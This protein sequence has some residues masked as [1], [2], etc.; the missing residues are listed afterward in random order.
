MRRREFLTLL[1][2]TAATWPLAA[3]AQQPESTRKIAILM[4]R[5]ANDAEGE[6]RLA[7]F[8]QTLQQLGWS[9]GRN[10]RFDIRYGEDNIEIERKFASELLALAPDI[11]LASG[12]VSMTALQPLSHTLPI[13]FAVVTDP[14]GAGFVSSLA[15]PG[16][17]A[18]GFMLYE[19]GFGGKWLE[20]LKQIAPSVSRAAIL[21]D[22]TNPSGLAYMAVIRAAAQSLGMDVSPISMSDADEI[23]RGVSAFAR[24]A[25]GAL[26]VTPNSS[27]SVNRALIIRLAARYK[28]PAIYPFDYFATAGGLISYG[29]DWVDQFR[30]AA[31]YVDRILKGEKPADLPVQAPTKYRLVI[32]LKTVKALGLT[33][34]SGMLAGADE[35]IE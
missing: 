12:T 25:N 18:T 24:S 19:Y 22:P 11:I 14:V 15:Q 17:N 31:G 30:L 34:P 9:E 6:A 23:D 16:G 27:A 1:G 2:T 7:A 8:K 20:L 21:R 13:V 33:I 10:V 32:N 4:N 28:L 3:R 29:P 26:I 35:V 5:A